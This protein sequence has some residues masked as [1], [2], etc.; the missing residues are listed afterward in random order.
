MVV[1]QEREH[2]FECKNWLTKKVETKVADWQG[3]W[4]HF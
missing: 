2:G 4:G 1:E 3:D